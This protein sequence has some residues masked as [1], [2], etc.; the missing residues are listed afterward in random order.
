[1][2]IVLDP[3]FIIG[4][5]PIPAMG[6]AGA[7]WATVIAQTV[8]AVLAMRYIMR[9]TDLVGTDPR[10]WRVDWRLAGRLFKI[11]IPAALQS[12]IVSFSMVV[13]ASLVNTF[14]PTVVAAFGAAGR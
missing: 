11:G 8:S 4:W 14:G 6:V 10:E 7:A 9:Y 13:V 1:L 2:N 5:G 12:S 3:P